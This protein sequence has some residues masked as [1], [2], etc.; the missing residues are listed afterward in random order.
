MH[1]R[2]SAPSG[3]PLRSC[4][5]RSRRRGALLRLGIIAALFELICATAVAAP[6]LTSVVIRGSTV[7]N[8][9]QL[10][11]VYRAQL[12]KEITVVGARAIATALVAKYE[13]DGYSR[14]QLKVDDALTGAG[15]LR[16]EVFEARIATVKI[17]GDP[18]PHL[19]RL[20]QLGA[21]LRSDGPVV[22]ADVQST[23]RRMRDLPGLTLSASTERDPSEPNLYSLD[24]DTDFKPVTGAV[25]LSNRGTDE[26]GPNFV[27]GQVVAN[28]LLGGETNLGAM[29]GAATDYDE[30]HGLG[31]L[32][33]VGLGEIGTRL[34]FSGFRSRSDPHEP[35]FDRDDSYLRDRVTIGATRP[36]AAMERATGVLSMTLDLDDLEI[37]RSGARLRDERL[38]MLEIVA[39]FSWRGGASQYAASGELV[40]GLGGLNSGLAALDLVTDP[41]RADFLLTRLNFT[42][43]TRIGEAWSLRFDG[44]AQQS[45]Y[46]LPYGQRFKIG[47]DRLGRGFEVAEIAGDLGIGGKVEGRRQ[48][49]AAPALLGRA[50]LYGFYD[51]GAT[52]KQ[53]LPGRESAA[54]A[55]FGFAS[56]TARF[57][58]SVEVAAPLTHADVEGQKNLTLFAELAVLF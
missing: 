54:T 53:D 37:V 11:D 55:G 48:L 14:P 20:E 39:S 27:L 42:R 6:T 30:Y 7:Y 36:F 58:G 34:A 52:W 43:L 8:A 24:L 44:L 46:V 13:G 10:F 26:A 50:S 22:Q 5:S 19:A 16:I 29:F 49:R 23:L 3:S 9:P 25:R 1:V 51:I 45:A 41:R 4:D 12:G 21:R 18:G 15:V 57:S 38:R 32:S 17:N 31:I 40:K 2:R 28:G 35:D 56:Q 33:N 47:G